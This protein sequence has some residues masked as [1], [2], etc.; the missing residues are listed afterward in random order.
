M[1]R[2]WCRERKGQRQS[3][4]TLLQGHRG[5]RL[6][7]L[8]KTLTFS[9]TFQTSSSSAISV[10]LKRNNLLTFKERH[11]IQLL[12]TAS[13][14]EFEMHHPFLLSSTLAM[15]CSSQAHPEMI[16]SGLQ[17]IILRNSFSVAFICWNLSCG[18]TSGGPLFN[19][20][21]SCLSTLISNC[22]ISAYA[23]S[24]VYSSGSICTV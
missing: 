1:A 11:T 17:L 18:V 22:S 10:Q 6:K 15:H 24:P 12:S 20:W 16:A 13:L 9:E 4:W 21:S 23:N 8:K 5:E 7:I 14:R 19:C 3:I 2:E